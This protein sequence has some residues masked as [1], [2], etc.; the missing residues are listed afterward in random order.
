[1]SRAEGDH[2]ETRRETKSFFSRKSHGFKAR[3]FDYNGVNA[4]VD[5]KEKL[6][7]RKTEIHSLAKLELIL[8]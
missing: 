5:K 8:P 1:M 7:Y 4:V 2:I 3:L 6:S